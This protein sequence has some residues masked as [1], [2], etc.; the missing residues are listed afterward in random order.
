M[1]VQEIRAGFLL[2]EALPEKVRRL[3]DE[4]LAHVVADETPVALPAKPRLVFHTVP[5]SAIGSAVQIEV[6]L[7]G[8]LLG[9]LRP[10]SSSSGWNDRFNLDGYVTYT[11]GE[12][13]H[14]SYTQ[15]MRNGVIEAVNT[16]TFGESN[17]GKWILASAI[18]QGVIEAFQCYL[19]IQ[20]DL[21]IP[22]PVFVLLS[23]LGVKGRR[24][25]LDQMTAF[26]SQQHPVDRDVVLLPEL[27]LEEYGGEPT[28]VL[29][30]V[31]DALWQSAGFPGSLNYNEQGNWKPRE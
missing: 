31:F 29:R 7:L 28:Q 17:Q 20:K 11:A 4:R 6:P 8:R 1:D 21:R 10:M 30:P 16:R 23:L 25:Y 22:T 5:A 19:A 3:R 14:E 27:F 24:L 12:G 26:S 13:T 18:E 15:I 2:S 9:R